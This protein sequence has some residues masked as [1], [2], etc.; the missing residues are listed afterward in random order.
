MPTNG[1]ETITP[2][3]VSNAGVSSTATIGARGRVTFASCESLTLNGI[4]SSSYDNYLVLVRL[5]GST[6]NFPVFR[7]KNSGGESSSGY[8]NQYLYARNNSASANRTTSDAYFW[9]LGN[10]TTVHSGIHFYLYGPFLAERT[11]VRSV[12]VDPRTNMTFNDYAGTH[13]ASTSYTDLILR[14]HTIPDGTISGVITVYG[15]KK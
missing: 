9:T 6:A 3:T 15:F 1:I 2:V 14:T 8:V 7:L 10:S 13:T 12:N 11:S 5:K 4:F